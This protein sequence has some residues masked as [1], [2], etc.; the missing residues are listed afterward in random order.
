MLNRSLELLLGLPQ[1]PDRDTSELGIRTELLAPM[2]SVETYASR[3]MSVN[4]QRAL[5][6]ARGLGVEP[7]PPLLR[8]LAVSTLTRSDFGQATDFGERLRRAA[9]RDDDVVLVVEAAYVLGIAAFWQ[10]DLEVA[11]HQFEL[12][13]DRYRG[14]GPHDT[15]DPLRPRPEGGLPEQACQHPLVPR[16]ARRRS[17]GEGR[18]ARLGH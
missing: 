7:A 15:R 11:R 17:R 10:A 14:A 6:L 1:S 5:A 12:A 16:S 13:V 8:S 9:D 4:Q 18:S 2:V 3:E